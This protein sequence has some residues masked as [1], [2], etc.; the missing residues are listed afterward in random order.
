MVVL[1]VGAALGAGAACSSSSSSSSP[2]G[3]GDASATGDAE[4]GG[5]AV[6]ATIDVVD[7][8]SNCVKPGTANNSQGVG[9]YC[10]SGGGQC[11]TAG[12]G[13]SPTTCS[14]DIGAV[15]NAWFCTVPCPATCG[16]GASC[17]ST[18]MGTYCTPAACIGVLAE[19]G[20][21][22]PEGG[23]VEGGPTDAAPVEASAGDGAAA[24]GGDASPE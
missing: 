24:D 1:V 14:A 7:N 22:L 23:I 13:G 10:N 21:L 3:E 18:S 9:G 2:G 16:G 20:V 4:G 17:V 6:D 15:P 8:P 11:A 19:A 5:G 12:P